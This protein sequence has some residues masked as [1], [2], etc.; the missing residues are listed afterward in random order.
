M[1]K[2]TFTA[3]ILCFL[4]PAFAHADGMKYTSIRSNA[5]SAEESVKKPIY[6]R[7]TKSAQA[8]EAKDIVT[9]ANSALPKAPNANALTK[10]SEQ[11]VW[12]KYKELASGRTE[13]PAEGKNKPTKPGK[14]STPKQAKA[15]EKPQKPT[16]IAAIISD[17]Q[18]KKESGS[19]MQRMQFSKPKKPEVAAPNVEKPEVK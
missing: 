16:G 10:T 8:P 19:K 7:K 15:K 18:R 14:P 6:N 4:S 11:S 3:L 5:A 2:F 12:D 9:E 17:Y 1:K 13:E